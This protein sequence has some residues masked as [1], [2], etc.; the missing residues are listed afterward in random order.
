MH[1]AE[2]HDINT[3]KVFPLPIIRK[4]LICYSNFP[5]SFLDFVLMRVCVYV[6]VRIQEELF[7]VFSKIP[8]FLVSVLLQMR[9]PLYIV[10]IF[11]HVLLCLVLKACSKVHIF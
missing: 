11:M 6:C 5:Q 8:R 4:H 1:Q 9:L 7:V 3:M 10:F 2:I